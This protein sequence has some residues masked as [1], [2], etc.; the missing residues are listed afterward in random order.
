MRLEALPPYSLA[1]RKEVWRLR[2]VI[3]S[4]RCRRPG[5]VLDATTG[6]GIRRALERVDVMALRSS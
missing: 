2:G 1:A 3:R 6:G 5:A 4:A